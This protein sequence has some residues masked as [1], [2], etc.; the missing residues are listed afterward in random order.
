MWSRVSC[1]RVI[2]AW[3]FNKFLHFFFILHNKKKMY[4]TMQRGRMQIMSSKHVLLEINE[5][6]IWWVKCFVNSPYGR[7]L[8]LREVWCCEGISDLGTFKQTY[9][10]VMHNT[11]AG[12]LSYANTAIPSF[13]WHLQTYNHLTGIRS[14][15]CLDCWTAAGIS[16]GTTEA[17][18]NQM[19]SFWGSY[20]QER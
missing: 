9:K 13:F 2:N 7:K 19:H 11:Y 10:R 5:C 1:V 20:S 8:C 14:L 16:D 12:K 15:A 6:F 4:S 18:P 17:P 3:V